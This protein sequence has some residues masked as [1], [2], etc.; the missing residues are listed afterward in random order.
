MRDFGPDH[1]AKWKNKHWLIAVYRDNA[2]HHCKYGSPA[3]MAPWIEKQWQYIAADFEL[4][5]YVPELINEQ[6][7][8]A[9][10]GRKDVYTRE[11]ARRLHKAQYS[12]KRYRELMDVKEVGRRGEEKP[13]GYSPAQM[14]IILRDRARY[15]IER[16]STL[17]NPHI[18]AAY[19][20]N[21]EQITRD[22]ALRLRELVRQWLAAAQPQAN[23]PLP[24][25]RDI[26]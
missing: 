9:I 10:V 25:Q 16:G 18:P 2:L 3:S 5:R 7:M 22:H 17:N 6:V 12:A 19:F 15:V 26:P 1:I 14:L 13:V 8:Y 23:V 20:A 24:A 11:D 21:W 4:A